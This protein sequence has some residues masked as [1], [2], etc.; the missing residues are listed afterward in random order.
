MSAMLKKEWLKQAVLDLLVKAD[1]DT[2]LFDSKRALQIRRFTSF[3]NKDNE[4]KEIEAEVSDT[5][6]W[7]KCRFTRQCE[8]NWLLYVF[9]PILRCC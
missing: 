7:I 8:E 4:G 5:F 3:R 1:S 2:L 9:I 6:S